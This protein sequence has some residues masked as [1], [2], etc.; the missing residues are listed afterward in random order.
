M[1]REPGHSGAA[2]PLGRERIQTLLV[3]LDRRLRAR[4]VGAT[5]YV[6]GG[7]A[8]AMTV[9]DRRVTRDVDVAALDLVLAEEARNLAIAEG[10]PADWLNAAAAPWIPAPVTTAPAPTSGLVVQFA[11]PEHLLAMKLVALRQQDAADIAA[12]TQ[13]LGMT[14]ASGEQL[15]ALLRTVYGGEGVLGQVLGVPDDRVDE[16]VDAIARRV[17]RFLAAQPPS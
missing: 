14:G 10:L 4:G 11:P 16:E 13:V 3:E 17:A 1:T 15:A 7:A 9:A 8:V 6:V 12:L 2:A 5:V